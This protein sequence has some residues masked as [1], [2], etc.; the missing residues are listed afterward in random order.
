MIRE[1]PRRK[2]YANGEVAVLDSRKS[3]TYKGYEKIGEGKS[4]D[5]KNLE[6]GTLSERELKRM[7]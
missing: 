7:L 1:L 5:S 3:K 4:S 2:G 6:I